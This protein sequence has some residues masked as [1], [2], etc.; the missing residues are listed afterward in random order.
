MG[1]CYALI[2]ER[3]EAIDWIEEATKWGFINY[4]FLNEIDPLLKNIRGEDRF[5]ELMRHVKHEWENFEV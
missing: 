3:E 2:D 4:L 5:K 1:E